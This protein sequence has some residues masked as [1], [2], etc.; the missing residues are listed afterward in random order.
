MLGR[1]EEG[2][3]ER[4]I[5]VRQ[6]VGLDLD[7][8]MW[9]REKTGGGSVFGR[10]RPANNDQEPAGG[11]NWARGRER[12]RESQTGLRSGYRDHDRFKRTPI[13]K[14]EEGR[15]ETKKKPKPTWS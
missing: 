11:L 8:V 10:T 1:V 15:E 13:R 7:R 2:R 6:C 9:G 12:I 5:R 14:V 3:K 4:N